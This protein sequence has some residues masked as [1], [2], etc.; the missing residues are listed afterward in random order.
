[1]RSNVVRRRKR[2]G[3]PIR[4]L[5]FQLICCIL[6]LLLIIAAKKMDSAL[7]NKGI[8]YIEGQLRRDYDIAQLIEE[9]KQVASLLSPGKVGPDIIMPVDGGGVRQTMSDGSSSGVII[10]PA[11]RE[12]QVHAAAGGTVSLVE[13]EGDSKIRVEI[14]HGNDIF[15]EYRGCS[16]VYIKPLSKVKQGQIIAIVN[17]GQDNEL[18]FSLRKGENRIDPAEYQGIDP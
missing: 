6:I 14:A 2:K 16:R 7:L 12:L 15:S 1:M 18:S 8:S 11:H 9:T 4:T 5:T 10:Y 17:K 3:H 13:R